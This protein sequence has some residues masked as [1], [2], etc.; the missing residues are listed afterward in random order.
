VRKVKRKRNPPLPRGAK[1]IYQQLLSIEARKRVDSN[2]VYTHPFD[3]AVS[4]IYG[5]PDG[6]LYI[7]ANGHRLWKDF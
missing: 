5:L 7:P 4:P 6:S 2:T 1:L 3:T